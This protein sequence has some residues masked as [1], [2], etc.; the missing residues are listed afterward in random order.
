MASEKTIIESLKRHRGAYMSACVLLNLLNELGKKIRCEAVPSILT[1]FPNEFN[2]VNNT[3]TRMQDCI[4]HMTLKS[5]FI[6]ECRTKTSRFRL[7]KTRRFY[8]RQ[9]ITLRCYLRNRSA[10]A[11]NC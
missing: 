7:Q 6:S 10:V 5:H 11:V 9:R 3:G 4:Y 1:V 8:G 2:K